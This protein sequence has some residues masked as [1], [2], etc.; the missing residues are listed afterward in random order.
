MVSS[1]GSDGSVVRLLI[2]EGPAS[3]PAG[4][5]GEPSRLAAALAGEGFEVRTTDAES[6]RIALA[7]APIDCVVCRHDPPAVDGLAAAASIREAAPDRPI[8]LAAPADH[9]GD[10]RGSA[11]T[12]V[13]RV[14]DGVPADAAVAAA[15]I[16]TLVGDARQARD[17]DLLDA[18]SAAMPDYAFV[19]DAEGRYLDVLTGYRPGEEDPVFE[20]ADLLGAT[21]E[22][23]LDATTA[24]AIQ[25]AIDEALATGSATVEYRI[26][27]PEGD[28]W[29]EGRLV[30]LPE[31]YAGREGVLLASR[32][33]TDRRER[34]QRLSKVQ[35]RL[36]RT[37]ERVDDAFFALDTDW[38]V[39]YVN[40]AGATVLR[41]AMDADYAEEE[42]LGKHLWEEIPDTVETT[43][44]ERYHEA[45]RTQEAVSFEEYYEP[46]DVW[47]EVNAYP[48]A[49]GLSVYFSD[50]TERHARER[51]LNR[52]LDATGQ[53]HRARGRDELLDAVLEAAADAL[54]HEYGLVRLHDPEA[55]TLEP[56][57]TSAHHLATPEFP[58]IDDDAGPMGVA[59]QSGEPQ[60]LDDIEAATGRAYGPFE[61]AVILPLGDHGT[62]AIAATEPSVFD[63][64]SVA[65]AE[66]LAAVA[67]E[68]LDRL[69]QE[70]ELRS[71][72]RILDR[73]DEMVFL[74][75]ANGAFDYV[76]DQFAAYLGRD[77][78]DLTGQPLTDVVAAADRDDCEAALADLRAGA[79]GSV[80]IEVSLHAGGTGP[81][82]VDLELSRA[83]GGAGATDAD[84]DT[85]TD[86]ED[87]PTEV[88]GS[89]T[90]ISELAATRT[91]LARERDRF[92]RLFELLPDPAVEVRYDD[93]SPIVERVNDA[94]ADAFGFDAGTL[95]GASLNEFVVTDGESTARSLDDRLRA[96]ESVATEVRRETGDGWRHFLLRAVPFRS[97]GT[98][99]ALAVYTDITEQKERERYLSVVNRV[100]RHNLR[101][102][103]T[104]VMGLADRLVR[105]VADEDLRADAQTLREN[106]ADL[107]AISERTKVMQRLAGRRSDDTRPIDLGTRLRDVVSKYREE[108][109]GAIHLDVPEDVWV[110]ATPDIERGFEELVENGLEHGPGSDPSLRVEVTE[111]PPDERAALGDRDV[112][113]VRFC[114][115]GPGVRDEEWEVVTGDREITQLTHA[116]G[117]GLWLTKWVVQ[118]VG[119]ELRRGAC[120]D[121]D[122]DHEAIEIVLRQAPR[123]SARADGVASDPES[124]P[125]SGS[126]GV[127][128]E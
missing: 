80:T 20:A 28:R 69:S 1:A 99:R 14:T 44:Y 52:L 120:S 88:A 113:V 47:F 49:D 41:R 64:E 5:D 18:L 110:E 45:M 54:G 65:R 118:S 92:R 59:F 58:T 25:G 22:D 127:S 60:V 13:I 32:E 8:L 111:A 16:E 38:R 101:N 42:L 117:L 123:G 12:D 61:S 29:Y 74:L 37:L 115:D 43:F 55:G 125:G 76:T 23:V 53:F 9:A 128:G 116:S 106:A 121:D 36:E 46:L 11:A 81:R 94:F 71:L 126:G 75:D 103:L 112:V 105:E 48:D 90:D 66:L 56:A 33:V 109:D 78:D 26:D 68:A 102:D 108:A 57:R 6:A 35:T 97:D 30:P 63:D 107:A 79:A 85:D 89:V 67:T 72:Q 34:E 114:D 91:D 17:A 15:R 98:T 2:V 96:G 95:V 73:V 70:S 21:V 62:L 84:T 83:T 104:V 31:P 51:T 24:D 3:D 86:G 119:G 77:R 7:A 124:T 19:Y 82:P 10:V 50:V 40:G 100:L 122:C 39:T 4:G 93:G 87:G 27:A